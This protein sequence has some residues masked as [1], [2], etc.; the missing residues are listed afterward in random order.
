[1]QQINW[2]PVLSSSFVAGDL[3]TAP[4]MR[5]ILACLK[6]LDEERESFPSSRYLDWA[7]RRRAAFNASHDFQ[8]TARKHL[9]LPRATRMG[10]S[11]KRRNWSCPRYTGAALNCS[12]VSVAVID[13]DPIFTG[14]L[15]CA[16]AR[17]YFGAQPAA[18]RKMNLFFWGQ[19]QYSSLREFGC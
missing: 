1:V 16:A 2:L 4:E 15:N 13:D 10:L 11:L 6:L 7:M 14:S 8:R 17:Q 3:P 9:L 12:N 5:H 18:L 19:L